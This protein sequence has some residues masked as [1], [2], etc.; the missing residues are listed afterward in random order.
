MFRPHAFEL[1]FLAV[2]FFRNKIL[3]SCVPSV[4]LFL[5]AA[6]RLVGDRFRDTSVGWT[7]SL[8]QWYQK[9]ICFVRQCIY[10]YFASAVAPW[11][12]ELVI[13]GSSLLCTMLMPFRSLMSQTISITPEQRQ[14]YSDSKVELATTFCFRECQDSAPPGS[15][16]I[17]P[18]VVFRKIKSPAQSKSMNATERTVPPA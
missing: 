6:I 1:F 3:V 16:T 17:I 10:S 15:R 12:S 18:R 9:S 8:V 14:V 5:S 11:V 13:V 4:F 2:D 7:A